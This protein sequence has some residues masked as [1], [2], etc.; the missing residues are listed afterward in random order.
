MVIARTKNPIAPDDVARVEQLLKKELA[1][2][3][4]VIFDVTPAQLIESNR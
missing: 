2:S 4:K 3:L 1:R